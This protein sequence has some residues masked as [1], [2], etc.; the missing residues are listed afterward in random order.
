ML[1]NIFDLRCCSSVYPYSTLAP[2]IGITTHWGKVE[3]WPS[4]RTGAATCF[5]TPAFPEL[6]S[7]DWLFVQTRHSRGS[8]MVWCSA[9]VRLEVNCF[10]RNWSKVRSLEI[11]RFRYISVVLGKSLCLLYVV[12]SSWCWE[13]DNTDSVSDGPFLF[14]QEREERGRKS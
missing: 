6:C 10:I 5:K 2:K 11:L 13:V 7:E 4:C 12:R 9:W 8:V 14:S 3:Q 1:T